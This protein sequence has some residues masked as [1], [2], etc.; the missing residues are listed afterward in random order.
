MS[1]ASIVSALRMDADADL[2]RVVEDWRCD[3][4]DGACDGLTP[5]A[6]RKRLVRFVTTQGDRNRERAERDGAVKEMVDASWEEA[7]RRRRRCHGYDP[8]RDD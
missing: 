6:L 5:G 3:A 7:N 2:E 8:R 1:E 4:M